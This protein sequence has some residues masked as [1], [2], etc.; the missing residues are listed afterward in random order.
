MGEADE[1]E[2]LKEG[3]TEGGVEEKAYEVRERGVAD[4]I[5]GPGAMVVH[6]GYASGR[7]VSLTLN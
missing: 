6:F 3:E 7:L 5:V 2:V 4:T 1:E